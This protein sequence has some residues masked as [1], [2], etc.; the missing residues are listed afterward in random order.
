VNLVNIAMGLVM[1]SII[2]GMA[3]FLYPMAMDMWQDT[4]GRSL[5]IGLGIALVPVAIAGVVFSV[6]IMLGGEFGPTIKEGFCYR[7]IG[8]DSTIY[9]TV[10]KILVPSTTRGVDLL[11]INCP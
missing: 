6:W 10:G 3:V 2:I 5:V 4:G 9:I 1:I 8:H 7:A 11:E